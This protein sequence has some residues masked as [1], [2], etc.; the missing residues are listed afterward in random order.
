M[1]NA[2]LCVLVSVAAISASACMAPYAARNP[3]NYAP[4][5]DPAQ[6]IDSEFNASVIVRSAERIDGNF[7]GSP[8]FS[9]KL[10]STYD[11]KSK[12]VDHAV[13]LAN[14][15]QRS[16]WRHWSSATSSKSERMNF[17]VI[18]RDV[19]SCRGGCSYLEQVAAILS[20]DQSARAMTEGIAVRFRAQDGM[21]WDVAFSP[22]EFNDQ[23]SRL[24]SAVSKY[25]KQEK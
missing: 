24:D 17:T 9:W 4:V 20:D 15:Y 21:Y 25:S 13:I 2:R 10:V 12:S 6:V 3:Y 11:K 5:A 19:G 22:E 1:I 7:Y 8:A 16:G 14:H 23:L 18:N